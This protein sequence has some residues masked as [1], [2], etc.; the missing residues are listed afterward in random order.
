MWQPNSSISWLQLYLKLFSKSKSR[1]IR[2]KVRWEYLV[3]FQ[4]TFGLLNLKA[5][6]HFTCTCSFGSNMLQVL[7]RCMSCFSVKNSVPTLW[8]IY[9]P[10]FK[11]ISLDW[12]LLIQSSSYL[13]KKIL[14][15]TTHPIPETLT[16]A[17]SCACSSFAWHI[18]LRFTPV[19]LIDVW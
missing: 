7:M 14:H 2:S 9:T 10:I 19:K 3:L 4:P 5:V 17:T 1:P 13:R 8:P 15:T 11:R 12:S 18:L 6:E 16:I